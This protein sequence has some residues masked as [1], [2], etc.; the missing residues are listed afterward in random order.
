MI[1]IPKI[2]E[3][4][5]SIIAAFETEVDAVVNI[6]GKA[7]LRALFAEQAGLMKVLYLTIGQ[8]QRNMT[9]DTCDEETLLRRGYLR[10]RHLNQM[11]I[12]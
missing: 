4:N 11:M 8:L 3:L 10:R 6:E 12:L 9:T 2:L 1:N 7:A 5:E